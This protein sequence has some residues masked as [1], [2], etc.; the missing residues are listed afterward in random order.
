M[1]GKIIEYMNKIENR[2]SSTFLVITEIVTF[3][4]ILLIITAVFD[5]T[6]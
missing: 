4:I 2:T 1:L 3:T 5:K 6:L